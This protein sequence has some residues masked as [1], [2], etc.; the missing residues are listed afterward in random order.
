MD[1][2]TNVH[3]YN[4][5]LMDDPLFGRYA[6]NDFIVDRYT[7]ARRK[8]TVAEKGG[9]CPASSI[10]LRTARSMS[11]VVTPGAT[12]SAA[13]LRASAVMR[14]ATRISSSSLAVL[15]L[16]IASKAQRLDG[17]LLGL[18][19]PLRAVDALDLALLAVI[20]LEGLGLLVVGRQTVLH[21]VRLVILTDVQ[22]VATVVAGVFDLR[23]VCL[24]VISGA[25]LQADAAAGHAA[26]R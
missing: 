4:V 10:V 2:R 12:A 20:L 6:V 24:D 8:A 23:R 7:G 3:L 21:N 15:M 16:I 18:M 1:V 26:P 9:L 5:A 14:Q 11:S 19:D 13:A 25:A 17:K 22:P